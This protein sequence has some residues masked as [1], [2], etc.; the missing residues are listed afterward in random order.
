MGFLMSKERNSAGSVLWSGDKI[1]WLSEGPKNRVFGE[2]KKKKIGPTTFDKTL[3][4]YTRVYK[5]CSNVGV[6]I[7]AQSVFEKSPQQVAVRFAWRWG[8]DRDEGVNRS[9]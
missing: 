2:S 5:L 6:G 9:W 4:A 7:F 3:V 1:F 8:W